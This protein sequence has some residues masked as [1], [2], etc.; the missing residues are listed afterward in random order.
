MSAKRKGPWSETELAAFLQRSR[1]PLR[2]ACNGGSGCPVLASLWYL[3]DAGRL[4]C[5]SPTSARVVELLRADPR[6]AFE[7]SEQEAPY[8]GMRGQGVAELDEDAGA[9]VLERL[10]RR[11]LA[12]PA[13][14]FANWLRN[15]AEHEV[16]IAIQPERIVTW[17]FEARM[18]DAV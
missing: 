16:A 3:E 9:E 10:I 2:L 17:D 4:W 1:A 11:Y 18:G 14:D 8:H 13:S 12:D 6:C 5:A 7:V 15:R